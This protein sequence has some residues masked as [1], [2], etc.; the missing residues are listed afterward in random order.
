MVMAKDDNIHQQHD[1]DQ[2][3]HDRSYHSVETADKTATYYRC[4][5]WQD[6]R[7]D[8]HCDPIF[9]QC[10]SLPGVLSFILTTSSLS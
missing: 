9:G 1:D 4:R 2:H 6:C 10:L 3:K 5:C 7:R 8:I